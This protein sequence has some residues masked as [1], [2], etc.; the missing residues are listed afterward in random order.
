VAE[1]YLA[2]G[3]N[4]IKKLIASGAI[5]AAAG[6]GGFGAAFVLTATPAV[7]AVTTSHVYDGVVHATL[8]RH[9]YDG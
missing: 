8:D 1:S 6:G 7:T 5:V 2:E 9:V 4:M 3:E